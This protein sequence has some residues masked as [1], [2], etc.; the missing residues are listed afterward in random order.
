MIRKQLHN[1]TCPKYYKNN[2]KC[3]I[4]LKKKKKISFFLFN[5]VFFFVFFS[6]PFL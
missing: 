6:P 2:I 1:K 5:C 4:V 3:K